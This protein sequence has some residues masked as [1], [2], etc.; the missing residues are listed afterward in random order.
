VP[1]GSART[2]CTATHA[3]SSPAAPPTSDST[4]LSATSCRSRRRR[5]GAERGAHRDL[6][7]ARGRAHQQQVGDVGAGD[8]Q[9]EPDRAHE[10][11][12]RRLHVADDLVAHRRQLDRQPRAVGLGVL[13]LQ[14]PVHGRQHAA[15]AVQRHPRLEPSDHRQELGATAEGRVGALRHQQVGGARQHQPGR[16]D[17]D[18]R[19]RDAVE[20]DR[21]ADDRRVATEAPLP[22]GVAEHDDARHAA[23]LL[24]GREAAAEHRRRAE[25][26]QVVGRHRRAARALGRTVAGDVVRRVAV[27]GQLAGAGE[28]VAPVEEV[29]QRRAAVPEVRIRRE[30][31]HQPVRLAIRQAAQQD[32]VDDPEDRRVDADPDREH[33]DDDERE[34]RCAV[35]LAQRGAEISEH[36]W[37]PACGG[38]RRRARRAGA[39][40]AADMVRQVVSSEAIQPSRSCT[41]RE[42]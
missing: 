21:P 26:A 8:Q 42:P 36:G 23:A 22:E 41:R 2:P 33:E 24:V 38:N 30:R 4:T 5:L 10:D 3:I 15:R 20:R 39:R 17:A 31:H 13:R 6:A 37:R 16:R 32:R 7:R 27:R 35:E 14:P 11:Q 29:G 18:H 25:H 12:Q 1:A 19:A 9:H 28:A 34:A 40:H